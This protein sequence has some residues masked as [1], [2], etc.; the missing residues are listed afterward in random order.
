M[1]LTDA[2]IGRRLRIDSQ[3]ATAAIVAVPEPIQS[4]YCRAGDSVR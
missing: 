2:C 3:P 4:D 1:L